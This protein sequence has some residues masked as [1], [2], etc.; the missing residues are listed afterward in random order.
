MCLVVSTLASGTQDRG[1]EP[2]RS[3]RIFRAKKFTLSRLSHVA[4]LRHVKTPRDLRGSR[5]RKLNLPANFRPIPSFTNR[6]LSCL[7]T[8]SASGDDGRN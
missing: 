4:D 7:L 8:W 2:G 1:F 3:L 5:N 6:G